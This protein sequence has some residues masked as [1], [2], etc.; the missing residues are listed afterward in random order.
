MS[1]T[2][3]SPSQDSYHPDDLFQSRYIFKTCDIIIKAGLR[4]HVIVKYYKDLTCP[5]AQG[6][7]RFYEIKL[8]THTVIIKSSQN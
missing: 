3:N 1:V 4:F 6:K 8:D 2:N 5:Q 7:N